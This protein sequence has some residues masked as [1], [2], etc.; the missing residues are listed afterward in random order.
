MDHKI[1]GEII[2]KKIIKDKYKAEFKM[3][4]QPLAH[5]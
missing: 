3:T 4:P 1:G 2:K 5:T